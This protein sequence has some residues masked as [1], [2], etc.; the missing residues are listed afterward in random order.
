MAPAILH[1]TLILVLDV[2]GKLVTP[3]ILVLDVDGKL[4]PIQQVFTIPLTAC[5]VAWHNVR[6]R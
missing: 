4:T 1:H 6:R 3:L 5:L 2:D